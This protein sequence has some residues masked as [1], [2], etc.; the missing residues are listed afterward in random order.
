MEAAAA[1]RRQLASLQP[2]LLHSLSKLYT[3]NEDMTVHYLSYEPNSKTQLTASDVSTLPFWRLDFGFG[4]PDRTRGYITS[5]GNGC[6]VLFGRN[7]GNK[8]AMY[9]VQL[10][11]DADSIKRFIDDPE[12]QKYTRRILY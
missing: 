2:S 10:Q 5:G 8:G 9:D 1:V 4:R 6:L 3:M 11:M 7:D 12:V